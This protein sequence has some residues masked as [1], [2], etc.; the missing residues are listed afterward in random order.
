MENIYKYVIKSTNNNKYFNVHPVFL[1]QYVFQ[2]DMFNAN[3]QVLRENAAF[4]CTL[5]GVK[6][7]YIRK[8]KISNIYDILRRT[9]FPP[10]RKI[11]WST[12]FKNSHI[13]L[14]F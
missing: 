12:V 9:R 11:F 10:K 1:I 8:N 3:C 5:E 2:L 14:E 4:L 7:I 13:F 6:N